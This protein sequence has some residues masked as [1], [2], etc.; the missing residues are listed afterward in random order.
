M[1]PS[2]SSGYD[3]LSKTPEEEAF[4][5]SLMQEIADGT[6]LLP[7]RLY[8]EV[9]LAGFIHYKILGAKGNIFDGLISLDNLRDAT[10]RFSFPNSDSLDSFLELKAY[11]LDIITKR[12][13]LDRKHRRWHN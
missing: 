3:S 9:T 10:H 1:M 4:T 11:I 12:G 13:H 5:F 2:A 7:N 8:W 6:S